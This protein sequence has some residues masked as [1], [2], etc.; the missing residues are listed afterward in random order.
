MFQIELSSLFVR[1]DGDDNMFIGETLNV[2]VQCERLGLYRGHVN[3]KGGGMLVEVGENAGC[4]S[5]HHWLNLVRSMLAFL[6]L[7]GGPVDA[8][9]WSNS[10][11]KHGEN[12]LCKAHFFLV[13]IVFKALDNGVRTPCIT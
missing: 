3:E 4:W 5:M 8:N 1:D 11:S 12:L 10:Q 7:Q 6:W 13:I 2:S 9:Y